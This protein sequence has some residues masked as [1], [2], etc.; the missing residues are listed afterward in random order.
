MQSMLDYKEILEG[1][2]DLKEIK[3][4]TESK[5]YKGFSF[6]FLCTFDYLENTFELFIPQTFPIKLPKITAISKI[7]HSHISYEGIVCLPN[8]EDIDYDLSDSKGALIKTMNSFKNLFSNSEETELKEIEFEFNDYLPYYSN[9]SE[10]KCYLCSSNVKDKG[11]FVIDEDKIL[12]GIDS[13]LYK[14]YTRKSDKPNTRLN[15]TYLELS[16]LPKI[17]YELKPKE[18]YDCLTEVS[19][20]KIKK[21]KKNVVTYFLLAYRLD[22]GIYNYIFIKII[23]SLGKSNNQFIAEDSK[24]TVFAVRDISFDFLRTRGG[25]Q[26][27]D[28]KILVVGCGSVGSEVIDILSSS[29]FMDI[30]I[31]DKDKL[32]Y[33]NTFRNST[34]FIYLNKLKEPYKISAIKG[35][36]EAKY[37]DV[38]ITMYEE[39][40]VDFLNSKKVSLGLFKYIIVCTGNNV[41]QRFINNHI[42]EKN[43]KTKILFGWL[44]PYGIAEHILTVDSS[45][46]G[47]YNCLCKSKNNIHFA[48]ENIDFKIRNNVCSG[49]YTPYGRI[50]TIRLATSI[51]E[52][53]LNDYNN[54]HFKNQHIVKKGNFDTYLKKGYSL[55]EYANYTEEQLAQMSSDFIF[56]GCDICGKYSFDE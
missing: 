3:E 40:I 39:D 43:I 45:K 15:F 55:T 22:N 5:L 31:I 41:L 13:I 10:K 1:I 44:E 50:S 8:Q 7:I 12:I 35:F 29:G 53:V 36:V 38:K 16:K 18:I 2:E 6:K 30:T 11:Q 49:S 4:V 23:A 33:E 48:P 42:Y 46:C 37:P 26:Q 25:S 20:E 21:L 34:G 47:C 52:L 54:H 19:L 9:Y 32:K 14:N 56:E 17:S 24:L 51:S 27:I 28:D